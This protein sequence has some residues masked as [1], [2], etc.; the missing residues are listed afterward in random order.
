M[1]IAAVFNVFMKTV[2]IIH[3]LVIICVAYSCRPSGRLDPMIY[4]EDKSGLNC[5]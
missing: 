2:M 5:G 1:S 3:K 4:L